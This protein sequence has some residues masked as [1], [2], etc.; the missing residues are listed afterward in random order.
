MASPSRNSQRSL[1]NAGLQLFTTKLSRTQHTLP[2][3]DFGVSG[4]HGVEFHHQNTAPTRI[5][6]RL[7]DVQKRTQL[8]EELNRQLK[9]LALD[10]TELFESR[11]AMLCSRAFDISQELIVTRM[12][13]N[14][15]E[16]A[17]TQLRRYCNYRSRL[18]RLSSLFFYS[19]ILDLKLRRI[20]RRRLLCHEIE[21]LQGALEH[22]VPSILMHV[23]HRLCFLWNC[24]DCLA[25]VSC[26]ARPVFEAESKMD[27]LNVFVAGF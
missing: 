26:R 8:L 18:V 17:C 16:N 6:Q 10:K 12:R 14:D 7:A 24:V 27:A 1:L 5:S 20:Q 22:Q 11:A 15:V 25:L 21:K 2:L 4:L 9:D 13:I 3:N 23:W 19:R